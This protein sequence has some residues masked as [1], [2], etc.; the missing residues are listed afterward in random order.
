MKIYYCLIFDILK[1]FFFVDMFAYMYI[2][3]PHT[4]LLFSEV[5]KDIR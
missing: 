1:G 3:V 5:R 4:Y 2:P